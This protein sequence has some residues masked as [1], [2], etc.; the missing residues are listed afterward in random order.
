MQYLLSNMVGDTFR[1]KMIDYV[2]RLGVTIDEINTIRAGL[3]EGTPEKIKNPYGN[4]GVTTT[5]TDV[6]ADKDIANVVKYQTL[7]INLYP[8]DGYVLSSVTLT[9]DGSDVKATCCSDGGRIRTLKATGS[10]VIT[11]QAVSITG[12]S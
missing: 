3:I 8:K 5:L 12:N 9:M 2:L 6:Y 4:V 10:V 7:E 11:A 1:N